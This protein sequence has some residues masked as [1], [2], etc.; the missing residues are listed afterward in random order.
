MIAAHRRRHRH[1][2]FVLAA[3]IPAL[4]VLAW[5]ARHRTEEVDH[6]P[7]ELLEGTRR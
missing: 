4:A 6:L 1:T 3:L 2:W 7:P 5:L